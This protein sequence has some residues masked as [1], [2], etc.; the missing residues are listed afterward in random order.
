MERAGPDPQMKKRFFEDFM[1][2]GEV[3]FRRLF[4]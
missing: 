4:V 1:G 2:D 3:S